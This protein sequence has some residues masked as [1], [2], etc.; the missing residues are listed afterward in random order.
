MAVGAAKLPVQ[1]LRFDF[2]HEIRRLAEQIQAGSVFHLSPAV[3]G[4][5]QSHPAENEFRV[6]AIAALLEVTAVGHLAHHVGR[7]DEMA[8]RDVA[9][10]GDPCLD[11]RKGQL[12][13]RE[14]DDLAADRYPAG[15]PDDREK[16]FQERRASRNV[17]AREFGPVAG[18]PLVHATQVPDVV[19]QSNDDSDNGALATQSRVL[20]G[21]PLEPDDQPCQCQ[22]DVERVLAVVVDRVDAVIARDIAREQP[23]EMLEGEP[24]RIERL[25]R[26]GRTIEVLYRGEHRLRRAHLNGIGDVEIA[27]PGVRHFSE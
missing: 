11:L 4:E 2:R 10:V 25:L 13:A 12:V 24:Q 15:E 20:T 21:L 17:R 23:F 6:Q 16:L 14:M 1:A 26:P 8:E 3:C 5:G 7:A 19:E 9:R 27:S 18:F 22:R